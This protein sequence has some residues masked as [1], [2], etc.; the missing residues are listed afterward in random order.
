L[1]LA[2]ESRP[3][4][5]GE[6]QIKLR[7]DPE[8]QTKQKERRRSIEPFTD[9][10][11]Q[12]LWDNLREHRLQ[13]AREQ[14]V[15]PYVIFSDAS[16]HEM[17]VYQPQTADEMSRISGVGA[18]KLERYGEGFLKALGQHHE[19]HGRPDN[20]PPLP[21][22]PQ[23]SSRP[24]ETVTGLSG[25]ALETLQYLRQGLRPEAIAEQRALKIDTI[26]S[27][28]ARCIEEGE[29]ESSEVL[30]LDGGTLKHIEQTI[31]QIAQDSP[32]SLK[33]VFEHFNGQHP[34]GVLRCIR[35][36]MREN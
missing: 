15:P 8:R 27:H 32:L 28:L 7:R 20:L 14:N 24:R 26:Y 35:A 30:D 31:Q 9:P 1:K 12:A 19:T 13:L 22:T 17:V 5:R 16:L 34:Y 4:L 36:G 6:R 2:D 11:S 33:P 18:V 3:V 21:E 29:I 23:R 10:A 25:T